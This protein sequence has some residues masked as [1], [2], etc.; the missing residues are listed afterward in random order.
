MRNNSV[1]LCFSFGPLV[2]EEM[3]LKD[4]SYLELWLPLCLAERNHLN[5]QFCRGH[6]EKQF[7]ELIL[8]LDQWFRRC[9]LKTFHI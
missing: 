8:N 2:Q 4:I 6:H 5:T 3:S 1:K 7:C 9:R